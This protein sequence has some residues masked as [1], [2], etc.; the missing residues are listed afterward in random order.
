METTILV[1]ILCVIIGM[2][3]GYLMVDKFKVKKA[4][5]KKITKTKKKKQPMEFSKK[6]LYMIF[7]FTSLVTIFSML[8]MWNTGD[9]SPLSY[10]FPAV[11]TLDSIAVGYYYWKSKSE[12]IIKIEK[13][14]GSETAQKIR[15]LED[16]I[17]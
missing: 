9:T 6:L 13:K 7:V 17:L 3:G 16:D 15:D 1:S 8:L 10:L 4:D 2:L 12:N 5:D 11:F 14:Y